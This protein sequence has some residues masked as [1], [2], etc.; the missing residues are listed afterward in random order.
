[1]L[2]GGAEQISTINED[3]TASNLWVAKDENSQDQQEII[4]PK[5]KGKGNARHFN[6]RHS[7]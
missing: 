2:L 7:R 6:R 4:K 5:S 1:M 3:L